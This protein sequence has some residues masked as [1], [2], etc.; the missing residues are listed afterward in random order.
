MARVLPIKVMSS[1]GT[2][3]EFDSALGVQRALEAGAKIAL[4]SFGTPSPPGGAYERA[5]SNAD[6]LGLVAIAPAGNTGDSTE[7]TPA[8]LPTVLSVASTDSTGRLSS[9]TSYGK[10]VK[11]AAPGERLYLPDK[12]GKLVE[13]GQ[14]TSYSAAV[15]ASVAAIVL[16]VKPDLT[17][18]ALIK[19]L[20]DTATPLTSDSQNRTINGGI[21]NAG[22]AV[23]KALGR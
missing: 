1:N 6:K 10:S 17:P 8:A 22:A 18:A 16:S 13:V 11:A 7:N 5:F 4:A 21:L 23:R 3:T 20:R 15:A 12:N 14:G 2:G 9:F 19:L